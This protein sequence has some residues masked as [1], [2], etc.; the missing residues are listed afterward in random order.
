MEDFS[1]IA[2]VLKTNF[3]GKKYFSIILKISKI[4]IFSLRNNNDRVVFDRSILHTPASFAPANVSTT[5]VRGV[6]K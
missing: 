2:T 6:Y 4:S 3:S 5:V 1:T